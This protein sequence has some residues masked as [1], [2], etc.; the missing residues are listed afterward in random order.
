MEKLVMFGAT[1][2]V[3]DVLRLQWSVH[4]IGY[5]HCRDVNYNRRS[6]VSRSFR[7]WNRTIRDVSRCHD[8]NRWLM[9]VSELACRD[10]N[11]C[12]NGNRWRLLVSEFECRDVNRCHDDNRVIYLSESSNVHICQRYS[13]AAWSVAWF[14]NNL[15][16]AKIMKTW[17]DGTMAVGRSLVKFSF[18]ESFWMCIE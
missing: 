7:L 10:V 2:Y 16:V 11:Q 6:K 14:Q 8:D 9:S 3:I 5:T 4:C 13:H 17:P 15:S 18:N 1:Y 12:H